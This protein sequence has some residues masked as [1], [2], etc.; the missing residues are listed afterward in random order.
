MDREAARPLKWCMTQTPW[1]KL[2]FLLQPPMLVSIVRLSFPT[3]M[4]L[5]SML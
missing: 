5:L 3:L 1:W 2:D 4:G